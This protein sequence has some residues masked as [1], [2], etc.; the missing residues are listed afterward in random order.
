MRRNALSI[1]RQISPRPLVRAQGQGAGRTV[2]VEIFRRRAEKTRD[3]SIGFDV[4]N[5]AEY[6]RGGF[7]LEGL[8]PSASI[9]IAQDK[10]DAD[11][12][13]S[14]PVEQ[15]IVGIHCQKGSSFD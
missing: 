10:R 4:N 11:A 9:H 15:V 3:V 13:L 6:V 8:L 7:A 5:L 12:R 1:I 14:R 2:R